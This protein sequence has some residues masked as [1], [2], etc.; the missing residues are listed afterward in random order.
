VLKL[1]GTSFDQ[2]TGESLQKLGLKPIAQHGERLWLESADK[3]SFAVINEGKL[4]GMKVGGTDYELAYN[5]QGQLARIE[6][7][8]RRYEKID[9]SWHKTDASGSEKLT[10]APV[11]TRLGNGRLQ[12]FER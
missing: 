9:G 10:Q 3:K 11:L 8:S 4:V 7:S 1:P 12:F 6:T 5:S 2:V